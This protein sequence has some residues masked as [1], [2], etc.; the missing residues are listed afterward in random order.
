MKRII[1]IALV[2]IVP[3][4]SFAEVINSACRM[5]PTGII[6]GESLKYEAFFQLGLIYVDGAKLETTVSESSC[7]G[8]PS[9]YIF[10]T[11]ETYKT[12]R[13]FYQLTDTFAVHISKTTTETL[14]F[15]E[16][17]EERKWSCYYNY[18]FYPTENGMD[19]NSYKKVAGE[20]TLFHKGSFVNCCPMDVMTL[21]YRIRCFDVSHL[22]AGDEIWFDNYMFSDDNLRTCIKYVGPDK[23]KLR[24]GAE[25]DALKFQFS[26]AVDGTLF[27][28]KNPVYI[29]LD[30]TPDHKIIHAESKLTIGYVK[31]DL[32]EVNGQPLK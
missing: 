15:F 24:R 27:S 14:N 26:T 7:R 6:P 22:K 31:M 10:A 4:V 11:A 3:L 28:K 19:V 16:H 17:D 32:K 13:T 23:V 25:R 2:L 9:Y 1:L 5:E 18:D 21:L 8:I 12:A 20:D 29:W 30:V